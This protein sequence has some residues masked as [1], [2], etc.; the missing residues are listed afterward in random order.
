M[1]RPGGLIP[2]WSDTPHGD[3]AA[4][5]RR[6]HLPWCRARGGR[7]WRRPSEK[8][9]SPAVR[10][11]VVTAALSARRRRAGG[12]ELYEHHPSKESSS[13][14]SA[15][16]PRPPERTGIV[17]SLEPDIQRAAVLTSYHSIL[18]EISFEI[19]KIASSS[20]VWV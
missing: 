17:T 20:P 6:L 11:S 9:W 16:C 19:D 5:T 7:A 3:P 8:T 2:R 4:P 15:P 1:A 18:L 14:E 13:R 10:S 12:Q